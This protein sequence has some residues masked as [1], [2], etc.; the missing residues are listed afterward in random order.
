MMKAPGGKYGGASV[1][2]ASQA[3]GK[4]PALTVTGAG[5][6]P[7]GQGSSQKASTVGEKGTCVSPQF[8]P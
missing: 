4:G 6:N 3:N 1:K 8:G 2:A 7:A 5:G